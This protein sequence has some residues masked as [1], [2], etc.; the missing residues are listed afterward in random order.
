MKARNPITGNLE[1]VYVKAFDGIPVG[2]IIPFTSNIPSLIPTGYMPC[3][4][5][6][7]LRSSYSDLFNIIGTT[8]GDGDGSTTFNLPDLRGK[9]VVGV[10][11]N[12]SDFDTLGDTGGE[13]KHTLT[14]NEMPSHT[15]N[16][17]YGGDT[18]SSGNW[19]LQ[20]HMQIDY[21][22]GTFRN[23]AYVQNT[24]GGESH[25]NLQPY[26]VTNYIIK[27]HK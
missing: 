4:G 19:N 10:D 15:H 16:L 22:P 5:R 27:E 21:S 18:S 7:I 17:A 24:G 25:N 3:D 13:K 6:A 26:L 23:A 20:D 9:V 8:Y 11:T 12:D 14:I 1:N 2:T